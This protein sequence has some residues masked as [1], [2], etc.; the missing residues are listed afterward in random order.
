[1]DRAIKKIARNPK[2]E[3]LENIFLMVNP[4][5]YKIRSLSTVISA[6]SR[7]RRYLSFPRRR[8]SSA[9]N[10]KPNNVITRRP[11]ASFTQ[12]NLHPRLF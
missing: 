7:V 12:T 8:E 3:V 2:K 6:K 1:M 4:S 10:I 9:V 11:T 5:A